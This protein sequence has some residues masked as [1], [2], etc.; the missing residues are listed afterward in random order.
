MSLIAAFYTLPKTRLGD[1]LA[2]ATPET[3]VVEK[4][5]LLFRRKVK[6][7]VDRFYEFLEQHATEQDHFQYSGAAVGDLMLLLDEQGCPAFD[8][9]LADI[10]DKLSVARD[11]SVVAFDSA[12]A[13]AALA[14]LLEVRF[15]EA[16]VK[17]FIQEENL[18]ED[19]DLATEAVL[20]ALTLTR[21]WLA[22]VA[23]D[24]IGLLI[25]G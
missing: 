5:G 2:A 23:E 14:A 18:P 6:Q 24:E 15:D 11:A 19:D 16:E 10:S 25:V 4:K 12:A 3:L 20:A 17:R 8:L 7:R 22:A 13:A 9:A 21:K 1:L